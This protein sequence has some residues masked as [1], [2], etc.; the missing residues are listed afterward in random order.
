MEAIQ[1]HLGTP[2]KVTIKTGVQVFRTLSEAIA[3]NVAIGWDSR[4][5]RDS[6]GQYLDSAC[7]GDLETDAEVLGSFTLDEQVY[8]KI[9]LSQILEQGHV[10]WISKRRN[11]DEE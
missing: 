5:D 6:G 11:I 3:Y 8:Y 4:I 9:Y 1:A 2:E 7:D 10:F